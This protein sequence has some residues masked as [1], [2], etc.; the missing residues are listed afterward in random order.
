MRNAHFDND[1]IKNGN[2]LLIGICLGY[3][4]CAEHEIGINKLRWALGINHLSDE[5]GLTRRKVDLKRGDR[6]IS[7]MLGWYEDDKV[8]GFYLVKRSESYNPYNY[9]EKYALKDRKIFSA[10]S[11]SEFCVFL[12][13]SLFSKE[14]AKSL[15]TVY[16]AI[17]SDDAVVFLKGRDNPFA[18][19]GLTICI[20]SKLPAETITIWENHDKQQKFLVEYVEWSGILNILRKAGKGYFACSPSI[21][22]DG[23]IRFWL[24]PYEQDRNN[25]GWYTLRDLRLWAQNKGPIPKT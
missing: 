3:D 23:K 21:L 17:L 10:W 13:K 6:N 4:Y 24:N 18:G 12:N 16:N 9:I 20:A 14:E 25:F 2:G 5:I 1:L 22:K 7:K 15:K 11:E 19:S 8:C